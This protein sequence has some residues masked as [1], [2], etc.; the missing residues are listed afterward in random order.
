M[1]GPDFP[2][3]GVIRGKSGIL[4]AYST[5]HGR[6]VLE[7]KTEV[8]ESKRSG[9]SQV[10][11]SE[12]PYQVNKS[13]LIQKIASLAKERKIEGITEVRDESDLRGIRVTDDGIDVDMRP[14]ETRQHPVL[15]HLVTEIRSACPSGA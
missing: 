5:G 6:I 1:K 2:T 11:I 15:R 12:L 7:G 3:G 4:S 14:V 13:T 8:E 9:R 10:V